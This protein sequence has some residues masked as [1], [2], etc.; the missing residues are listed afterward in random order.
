MISK[1]YLKLLS[2]FKKINFQIFVAFSEY[3]NLKKV[4][5]QLC[6]FIGVLASLWKT[7][8]GGVE[9]KYGKDVATV[10]FSNFS[11]SA[12]SSGKRRTQKKV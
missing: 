1:F 9:K 3:L 7:T 12:T 11:D 10:H 4:V 8:A 6:N 2:K 5:L